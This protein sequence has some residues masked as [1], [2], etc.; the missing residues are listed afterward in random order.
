MNGYL[1]KSQWDE[2]WSNTGLTGGEFIRTQIVPVAP[3]LDF[4]WPV[5]M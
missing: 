1:D 3:W 5:D 4:S 2:G